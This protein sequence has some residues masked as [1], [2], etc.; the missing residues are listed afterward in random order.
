M[1]NFALARKRH[2][3]VAEAAARDPGAAGDLWAALADIGEPAEGSYAAAVR[4]TA[5]AD[6]AALL[7]TNATAVAA[8]F[9]AHWADY[10]RGVR[11]SPLALRDT[12]RAA[13]AAF[14]AR[15]RQVE[16]LAHGFGWD[17]ATAWST[18]EDVAARDG[19]AVERV[20]RLAGRMYAALR[21]ARAHRVAGMPEE[22]HSVEVGGDI[23]RLLPSE[24]A[25]LMDADMEAAVLA[26]V[27]ERRALQYEMRGTGQ[28]AKGPLVL[29]L[30]ESGSMHAERREWS[31]AAAIAL[32]RVAF[33][34]KRPVA[35]VHFSTSCAVRPLKP[36][37]A[38]S[39]VAMIR[40]FLRGGTAIGRA[41][42]VAAEQVRELAG[43]GQPGGDVVLVT[44]GVDGDDEAQAASVEKLRAMSARL[45][46]VA[47]EC[48]IDA[49]S[50][51]RASAA[52]YLRLGAGDLGDEKSAVRLGA[53]AA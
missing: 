29:A 1:D 32:A 43:R 36:G 5:P 9:V 18:L 40:S 15:A 8:A 7:A 44:D 46:T 25:Q 13:W 51:L 22:V 4:D 12:A 11:R 3:A 34:E 2:Q 6:H 52:A 24:L 50:P 45:W 10:P 23:P 42:D 31:K 47:I 21:G 37:D 19:A 14:D 27:I 30:D 35:V 33:D 39:V 26:R 38:G 17:H 28:R 48:D 16:S 53:A 20:A 41:L 49:A